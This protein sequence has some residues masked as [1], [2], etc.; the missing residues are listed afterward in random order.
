[1]AVEK[2]ASILSVESGASKS[3]SPSSTSP[4]TF[5]SKGYNS[6]GKSNVIQQPSIHPRSPKAH[7]QYAEGQKTAQQAYVS[8]RE[9]ASVYASNQ[10][11]AQSSYKQAL[12]LAEWYEKNQSHAAAEYK[13]Q[14][15]LASTYTHSRQQARSD[16]HHAE[17]LAASY[18][19]KKSSKTI[20]TKLADKINMLL[21]SPEEQQLAALAAYAKFLQP[22]VSVVKPSLVTVSNHALGFGSKA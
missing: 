6:Q 17:S 10:E 22:A 7:E 21:K 18:A 14:Q 12:A 20:D 3:N 15:K 8:D 1:M 13:A 9:T 2:R 4:R 16:H 19:S 11:S 5:W